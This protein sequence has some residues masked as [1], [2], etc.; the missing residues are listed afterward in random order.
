MPL[1]EQLIRCIAPHRC[2]GCGA[3]GPLLCAWCLT[4]ANEA[5]PPRCFRCLAATTD[6]AV[7]AKCRRQAPLGHVWVAGEYAGL[8][9]RLIHQFKF[10]RARAAALPIASCLE[11]TLP[12]L[13]DSVIISHIP[14]APSRVRMRGYD[15]S[16]LIASRLAQNLDRQHLTLLVRYG[17]SRQVGAKRE[18][19]LKQLAG[20]FTPLH[21]TKIKNAHIL[22]I[23]D[24]VTS[25]ATLAE[26]AKVLKRAGAKKV[27]AAVFAQ[28]Q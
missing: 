18:Q 19:R 28:A 20:A 11:T 7:C 8:S 5:L 6:S 17:H 14:A 22:L 15:Q 12:Y 2:L 16:R 21:P 23:D 3:V 4:E 27:D 26:A 24:V 25:G 1:I 10:E 9:K 13:D